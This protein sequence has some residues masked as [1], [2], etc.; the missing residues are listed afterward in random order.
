MELRLDGAG[1]G[2]RPGG[3][4][5]GHLAP[6][7]L[8]FAGGVRHVHDGPGHPGIRLGRLLS[9]SVNPALRASRE[10]LGGPDRLADNTY[11]K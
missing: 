1:P 7:S 6:C 9:H 3:A 5:R 11:W 8:A 2:D 10:C 4:I